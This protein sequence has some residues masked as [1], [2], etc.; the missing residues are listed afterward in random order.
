MSIQRVAYLYPRLLGV[1]VCNRRVEDGGASSDALAEGVNR[2]L[3]EHLPRQWFIPKVS[4]LGVQYGNDLMSFLE[5]SRLRS[6]LLVAL[7]F[8]ALLVVAMLF[9]SERSVWAQE[10]D[11]LNC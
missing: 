3:I 11:D 4:V 2:Q 1:D 9:V 5:D 8:V 7:P 6:G 10:E